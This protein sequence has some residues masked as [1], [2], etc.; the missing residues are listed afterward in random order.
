[1]IAF[2][3]LGRDCVVKPIFGGEGRGLIRV[4]DPEIAWRVFGAIEQ[5][6]GVLYLQEFLA[7]PGYDLRLLVIGDEVFSVKRHALDDWRTNVSRG[8]KATPHIPTDIQ[9]DLACERARS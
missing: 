5:I 9:R 2:E 3:K 1:M 4:N 7:H 8:G 6:A